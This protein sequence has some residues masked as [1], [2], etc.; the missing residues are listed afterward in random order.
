[1][2]PEE[3]AVGRKFCV[4]GFFLVIILDLGEVTSPLFNLC[5]VWYHMK[6]CSTGRYSNDERKEIF[7]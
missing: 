2:L 5:V 7:L 3:S 6:K 1:M 4:V